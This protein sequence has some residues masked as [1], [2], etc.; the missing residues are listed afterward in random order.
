MHRESG[1][2]PTRRGWATDLCN[3]ADAL[4]HVLRCQGHDLTDTKL[5][6]PNHRAVYAGVIL[7]H[8]NNS[9]HHFRISLGCVWVKINHDTS[10]VPHSNPEGCP[11][12]P[13]T[14]H[15]CPAHPSVFLKRL[16]AICFDHNV[17]SKSAKVAKVH[18]SA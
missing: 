16:S 9:L 6:R 8:T 15:Q 5:A 2:T 7:V 14:K 10:L 3:G 12:G 17:W 13:F 11:A 4:H 1:S 18:T